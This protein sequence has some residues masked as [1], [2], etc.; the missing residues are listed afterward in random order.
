MGWKGHP[1]SHAHSLTDSMRAL[2]PLEEV[3]SPGAVGRLALLHARS[4]WI[5]PK[6]NPQLYGFV[7]CVISFGLH[8]A[9]HS[10]CC[11]R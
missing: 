9:L 7:L 1:W 3:R 5:M 4:F 8:A 6:E 10:P 11:C 2:E